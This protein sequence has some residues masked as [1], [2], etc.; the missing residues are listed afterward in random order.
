MFK[1]FLDVTNLQCLVTKL[2][3]TLALWP[4][5]HVQTEYENAMFLLKFSMTIT[6]KFSTQVVV[7]HL[8][9]S[10]MAWKKK[11]IQKLTKPS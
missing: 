3:G 6:T 7:F 11:K 2:K 8:P 4:H 9:F 1:Y 10:S 5:K